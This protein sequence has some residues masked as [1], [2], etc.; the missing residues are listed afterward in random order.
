MILHR[1]GSKKKL[2]NKIIGYFPEHRTYIEL[3]F[4]GGSIF[5]S[6]C[7]AANNFLNDIDS[8]VYNLFNIIRN[9]KDE[10]LSAMMITLYHS[11]VFNEWKSKEEDDPVWKAV[12]FLMLSNASYLGKGDTFRFRTNDRTRVGVME[13]I[14]RFYGKLMTATF[15]NNDFRDVLHRILYESGVNKKM[16]MAQTFVYA[17]PPYLN[18]GYHYGFNFKEKDTIDLFE[19]LCKSGLQF[20]VSEFNNPLVM[21]IINHQNLYCIELGERRNL[22]NRAEEVL[23]TNYMPPIRRNLFT[24]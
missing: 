15:L 2:A 12:R 22:K 17:D 9:R 3:F 23:I 13:S 7:Q 10:L 4:G 14:E 6:K 21:E 19:M 16:D 24:L 18:T 5:F 8:D 11:Q 1:I 20:A